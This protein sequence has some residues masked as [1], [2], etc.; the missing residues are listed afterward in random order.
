MPRRRHRHRSRRRRRRLGPRARARSRPG[1]VGEHLPL[2]GAPDARLRG[3]PVLLVSPLG[4]CGVAFDLRRGCSL[5]E[6]LVGEGRHVHQVDDED[7]IGH[8]GPIARD[9]RP[10]C[11]AGS[12]TSC[13]HVVRTV[14]DHHDGAPVHVV[15]WSIG[16]LLSVLAAAAHADAAD[17]VGHRV[18]HA[19]RPRAGAR[20][21]RRSRP[22]ALAAGGAGPR[23]RADAARACC[24]RRPGAAPRSGL[25]HLGELL[26][27][28]LT[29][30]SHLARPGLPR[31]AR[32][33]RRP[34]GA[35]RARPSCVGA[36]LHDMV[37]GQRARRR[38]GDA[39]G[40]A[41][42]DLGDPAGAR[43]CSSPASA[44]WWCP[45]RAVRA[46]TD[47]AHRRDDL[48]DHGTRRAPRRAVRAG[49]ARPD[50]AEALRVP[51]PPRPAGR[52]RGRPTPVPAL[53]LLPTTAAPVR[54]GTPAP[55]GPRHRRERHVGTPARAAAGGRPAPKRATRTRRRE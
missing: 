51:R 14:S 12:T 28:P 15:G 16:G 13:P 35:R 17:R 18:R 26:T 45:P 47:G 6:H 43:C 10:T 54:G 1:R 8:G 38:H 55:E 24:R 42:V 19:V 32:G 33:R 48:A 40:G 39:S 49:G 27:T 34:P 37:D 9:A 30:L 5:V 44:T 3:A 31:P 50:L 7:L 46:G 41:R 20:R 2:R 52:A 29:V 25:G 36:Y 53:P 23:D 21:G 4:A 22:L 11:S